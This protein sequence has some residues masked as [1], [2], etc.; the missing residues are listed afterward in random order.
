MCKKN[1]MSSEVSFE[2]SKK[3][4]KLLWGEI[5]GAITP[6]T[7]D[8]SIKFLRDI[9]HGLDADLMGGKFQ[10]ST[11]VELPTAVRVRSGDEFAGIY[12]LEIPDPPTYRKGDFAFFY[13]AKEGFWKIAKSGEV[14]ARCADCVHFVPDKLGGFARPFEVAREVK[15][16][17]AWVFDFSIHVDKVSF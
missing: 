8:E 15:H 7:V 2:E 14:V 5:R 11:F 17:V 6:K 9:D 3:E 12:D 1:N 13:E 16:G 4:V 10:P